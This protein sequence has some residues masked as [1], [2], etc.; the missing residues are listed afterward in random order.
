MNFNKKNIIWGL[1]ITFIIII[2]ISIHFLFDEISVEGIIQFVRSFGIFSI[3]I[4]ALIYIGISLTGFS[5]VVL[6]V[7]AG[8]L[9]GLWLGLIVVVISA[10]I[11]AGIGFYISRFLSHKFIQKGKIHNKTIQSFV[12]KIEKNCEQNGFITIAILRLSFLPYIPL[13]Y[14][15]GLVKTLKFRDFILATF[16]TNIF[17]SFVFIVLG[18]SLTQSWPL[19]VG[20]IILL[21]LFMWVPKVI[22]K[23]E[24]KNLK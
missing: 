19:F 6:T 11:S 23:I 16:L 1:F 22:K 18:A 10:T 13:S 3:V 7:L 8:T 24:E 12:E 14:A 9:F 4:F 20:A 17:G 15:T 21:I 2:L 5:A